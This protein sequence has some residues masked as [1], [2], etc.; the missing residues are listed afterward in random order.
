MHTINILKTSNKHIFDIWLKTSYGRI[1][2]GL[3]NTSCR[4][5]YDVHSTSN[6]YVQSG[7]SNGKKIFLLKKNFMIKIKNNNNNT[8]LQYVQYNDVCV[9]VLVLYK[10]NCP[11]DIFLAL[12]I[13]WKLL[14][15]WSVFQK[16]TRVP[17][18]VAVVSMF[19]WVC[20]WW[21]GGLWCIY[22]HTRYNTQTLMQNERLS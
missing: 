14:F 17:V 12:K 1:A 2:D 21:G 9:Q 10:N 18:L 15:I 7:N 4:C 20:V 22:S 6:V 16:Q 19:W 11:T 5:Q 3:Q 8:S 13:R